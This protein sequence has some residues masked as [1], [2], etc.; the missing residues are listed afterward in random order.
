MYTVV[1]FLVFAGFLYA[2]DFVP[3]LT[4]E[5]K[6]TEAELVVLPSPMPARDERAATTSTAP[7][8]AE[9]VP[10]P[11]RV[12]AAT[13]PESSVPTRITIDKIGV[14]VPVL[15][16]ASTDIAVLDRALLSGAVHYPGSG[17][18]GE[19]GNM[20]IFGHSSYLPVVKNDA[21]KAFNELSKLERGDTI[22]VVSDT[23][24]YVYS[25]ETVGLSRAEETVIVLDAN[26]PKLTLA[27]CNSFGDEQER[28]VVTATLAFQTAR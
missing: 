22:T 14:D 27:T 17:R 21:F 28:W 4:L 3:E 18:L 7:L 6:E 16:P 8:V 2:I 5:S 25:V 9:P 19:N 12:V 13:V 15:T 23:H 26:A 11:Q 24:R 1:V 20:L 10:T